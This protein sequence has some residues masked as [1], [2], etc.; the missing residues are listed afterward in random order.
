MAKCKSIGE[1]PILALRRGMD[2]EARFSHTPAWRRGAPPSTGH[3][4]PIL[5]HTHWRAEFYDAEAGG[6][7]QDR[8][9]QRVDGLG[10]DLGLVQARGLSV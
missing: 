7:V 9:V 6:S 5:G 8:F 1:A 10:E 3:P 4:I 2:L